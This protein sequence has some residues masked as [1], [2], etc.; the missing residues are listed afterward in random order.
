MSADGLN[1]EEKLIQQQRAKAVRGLIGKLNQHYQELIELR[2]FKEYSY[3]EISKALDL[4]L[5]TI[6]VQLFRARNMLHKMVSEL[7]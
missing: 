5:G 4:P 1:P 7:M 3:E 6:K 2:Y